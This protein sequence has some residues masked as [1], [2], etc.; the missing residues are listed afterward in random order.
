MSKVL[1]LYYSSYG[2]IE[3]MAATVAEGAREAGAQVDIKRVP[4]LVPDKV[5][6]ESHYKVD[7][8][9][10][11]AKRRLIHADATFWAYA[12][13]T[14]GSSASLLGQP[15]N[16]DRRIASADVGRED[17]EDP[18]VSRHHGYMLNIPRDVGRHAPSNRAADVST[19][20]Y[21][22]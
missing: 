17:T 19:K 21:F 1:V 4:E 11:V 13:P 8:V 10:P 20:Q 18:H 15:E 5:A 12:L 7:Q 3:A 2:H 9:A 6:R 16:A 14:P 22:S